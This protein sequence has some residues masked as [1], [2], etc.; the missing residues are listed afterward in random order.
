MEKNNEMQEQSGNNQKLAVENRHEEKKNWLEWSVFAL[1]IVLVLGI[2][3]YLAY[4]AFTHKASTP[5]LYVQVWSDPSANA[6]NRYHIL[7]ENK[8]G[9]T[10]E[11]VT[12]ELVLV[13]GGKEVEKAQLQIP[14]APQE[15]KREGWVNFTNN[16]I[17]ADTIV[18]RV[19]SYK[20][21]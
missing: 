3:V 20:K 13:Q 9:A 5:D 6:P 11:E 17:K 10:A 7:L 8:G 14:F 16:P 18:S 12:I 21:P 19:V 2:L 15:S 1:S 4:Q